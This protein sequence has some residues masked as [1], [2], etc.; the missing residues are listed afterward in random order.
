MQPLPYAG[1]VAMTI[2]SYYLQEDPK[3]RDKFWSNSGKV[4]N[5]PYYLQ[6]CKENDRQPDPPPPGYVGPKGNPLTMLGMIAATFSAVLLW[7]LGG[8]MASGTGRIKKS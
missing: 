3:A 5:Y 2:R 7:F 4:A 6:Y 1:W 8:V